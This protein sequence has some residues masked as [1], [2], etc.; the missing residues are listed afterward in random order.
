MK[1]MSE[2]RRKRIEESRAVR[3]LLIAKVGECELCGTSPKRPKHRFMQH[4]ELCCHE[5][6]NG[7]LRQKV[8]D[9]LSCLIVACWKC[10]GDE[11]NSKG[12]YPLARQLAIIKANAPWRYDRERVLR[13]RNPRAMSY[14]TE[15][16]VDSWVKRDWGDG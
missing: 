1:G 7:P 11:L 6:L 15:E 5:V 13:L 3:N 9:E 16:E 8:L 12:D 2:K 14:V 10:N 4:N